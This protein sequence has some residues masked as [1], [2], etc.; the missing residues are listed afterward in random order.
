MFKFLIGSVVISSSILLCGCSDKDDV[1]EADVTMPMT[2]ATSTSKPIE[3]VA[4]KN[5]SEISTKL[6]AGES[7][8]TS[9]VSEPELN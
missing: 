1:I 3:V 9:G 5:N 2:E 6:T 7:E 8:T 4:E